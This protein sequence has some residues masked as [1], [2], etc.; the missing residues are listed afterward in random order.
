MGIIITFL[1]FDWRNNPNLYC[2][3]VDDF[4]Y[5]YNNWFDIDAQMYF[6]EDCNA[7]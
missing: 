3:N 7:K 1:F 5:S 4:Q 6:S 2:I